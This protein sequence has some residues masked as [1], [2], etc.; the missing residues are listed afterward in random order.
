M[1]ERGLFMAVCARHEIPLLAINMYTGERFDYADR[2]LQLLTENHS[3]RTINVLYDVACRYAV[4]FN[5]F[6]H[7]SHYRKESNLIMSSN[8]SC[9]VFMHTRIQMRVHHN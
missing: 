9:L 7:N 8:F 5:V 3:K 2:L 1:D 6:F 4:N